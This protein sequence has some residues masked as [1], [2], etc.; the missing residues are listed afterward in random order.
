MNFTCKFQPNRHTAFTMTEMI[1]ALAITGAIMVGGAQLMTF[2]ARHGREVENRRLAAT[3][4]GNVMEQ[5]MTQP[6][7]TLIP[8]GPALSEL[9]LPDTCRQVLPD[10]R[11]KVTVADDAASQA[12]R[13]TIHIDWAMNATHRSP[14]VR[15]IAWRYPQQETQP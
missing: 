9:T 13:I 4:A 15:L 10:S 1:V 11:V 8:D 6:W 5:L 3:E 2:T 12:R 14:G 7:D